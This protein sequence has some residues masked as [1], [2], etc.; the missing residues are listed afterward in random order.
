MILLE[1][2]KGIKQETKL[3]FKLLE[4]L[5]TTIL[6][7]NHKKKIYLKVKVHKSRIPGTSYVHQKT[8]R[9][10]LI[11]LDT[12]NTKKRYLISSLL[13]EIRH[14]LQFNLFGFW[15]HAVQF[16]SWKEYYTSREEVDARKMERLTTQLIKIY[17][18]STKLNDTFRDLELS[19]MR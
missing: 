7:Y 18:S 14:C 8:K 5:L 16:K 11:G 10:Y 13:H 19:R 4:T 17:D 6:E 9:N 12:S 3:D 1:P 15:N 2:S